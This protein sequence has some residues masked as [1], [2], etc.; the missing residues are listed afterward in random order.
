[1][2]VCI[3]GAM[4]FNFEVWLTRQVYTIKQCKSKDVT[5]IGEIGENCFQPDGKRKGI[6][7]KGLRLIKRLVGHVQL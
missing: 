7:A 2:F 5:A 6:K 1:M 4:E 3:N